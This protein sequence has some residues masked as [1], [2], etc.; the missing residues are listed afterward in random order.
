MKKFLN[1]FGPFPLKNSQ[2]KTNEFSNILT[3]SIRKPIQLQ[4][5][6]GAEFYN[7]NFQDFLK[8]KRKSSLI[9]VHR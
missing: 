7:S 2:T 5:D 3:T 6:R 4:S 1:M 9:K 8:S